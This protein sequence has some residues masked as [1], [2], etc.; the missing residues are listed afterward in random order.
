MI[1]GNFNKL[2]ALILFAF[3][4]GCGEDTKE[5]CNIMC[6]T[7]CSGSAS[8]NSPGDSAVYDSCMV[9]CLKLVETE[10]LG[11]NE[12]IFWTIAAVLGYGLLCNDS[13]TS[14]K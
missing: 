14:R 8:C 1:S 6:D 12:C 10:H 7:Q 13:E 11:D 3:L 9:D 5:D 4:I 2:L